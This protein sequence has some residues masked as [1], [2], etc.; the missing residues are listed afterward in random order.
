MKYQF[1]RGAR[2][3]SSENMLQSNL[4]N[5]KMS[6]SLQSSLWY[7]RED[8]V[9]L[10]NSIVL[11]SFPSP[12]LCAVL[13]CL[14]L[15][16]RSKMIH[17]QMFS[18]SAL[19]LPFLIR[20]ETFPQSTTSIFPNHV[21]RLNSVVL[22]THWEPRKMKTGCTIFKKLYFDLPSVTTHC[23]SSLL[24]RKWHPVSQDWSE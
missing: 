15:Q 23:L 8:I 20:S 2:L 13:N 1:G 19:S 17:Y 16:E 7:A 11:F 18:L 3:D 24:V 21:Q 5:I 14:L 22:Q 9:L 12:M 6:T 4:E 10:N